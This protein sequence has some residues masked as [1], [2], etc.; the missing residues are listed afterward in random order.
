M[1]AILAALRHAGHD[2]FVIAF[3]GGVGTK[4]CTESARSM[5]FDVQE[6]AET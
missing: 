5:N 3:P 1:V 4:R 2:C 6:I